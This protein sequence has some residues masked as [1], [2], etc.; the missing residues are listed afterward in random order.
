MPGLREFAITTTDAHLS[1]PT[2]DFIPPE[3]LAKFMAKSGDA[4][5]AQSA[6]AFE[7]K[8]A[9]KADNIGHK[10]LSKMGWREGEGVGAGG[11]GIT[12]PVKSSGVQ[13]DGLG[14]GAQVSS[15]MAGRH[16]ARSDPTSHKLCCYFDACW[17]VVH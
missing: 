15:Y 7:A 3:E 11:A 16:K 14:L 10:L 8:G 4:A 13:Q 9:I 1:S 12:A 5:A 6:Q 17:C 2:Q